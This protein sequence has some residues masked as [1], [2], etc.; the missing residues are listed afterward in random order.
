MAE[1]TI[2]LEEAKKI[3]GSNE[4]LTYAY[5]KDG[6]DFYVSDVFE[7]KDR[8]NIYSLLF[9]ARRKMDELILR[10]PCLAVDKNKGFT[11][12]EV[13]SLQDMVWSSQ[14]E[15][16]FKYSPDYMKRFNHKASKNRKG[17]PEGK[18]R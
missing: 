3:T 16:A 11:S 17:L 1:K 5:S 6:I 12:S 18:Y 7:D 2:F 13:Q 10:L 4:P 9:V 14:H 15:N 8:F